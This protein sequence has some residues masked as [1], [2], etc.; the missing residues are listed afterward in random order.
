MEHVDVDTILAEVTRLRTTD[1]EA[2]GEYVG[3][4]FCDGGCNHSSYCLGDCAVVETYM[5][6]METPNDNTWDKFYSALKT[7]LKGE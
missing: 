2:I 5:Q 6:Y 7:I 4:A 3:T 1:S